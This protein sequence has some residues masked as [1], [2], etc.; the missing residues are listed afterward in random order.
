[1]LKTL[2]RFK[3]DASG[4]AALEFALI[5]PILVT[6]FIGVGSAYDIYRAHRV[7]DR[8]AATTAELLSRY[9]RPLTSDDIKTVLATAKSLAGGYSATDYYTRIASIRN[10]YD[11][12][13]DLEPVFSYAEPSSKKWT[14]KELKKLDLPKIDEGESIVVVEMAASHN[15]IFVSSFITK[16]DILNFESRKPRFV[17][18]IYVE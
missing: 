11:N 6:L 3:H 13:D 7:V 18:E 15:P 8:A 5:F 4:I 12:K 17:K 14:D 2:K 10:P 16:L 9:D 1:M